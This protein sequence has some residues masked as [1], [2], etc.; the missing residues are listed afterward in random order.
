MN[1][2]FAVVSAALLAWLA[3]IL[4]AAPAAQATGIPQQ[5]VLDT[6]SVRGCPCTFVMTG[7]FEDEGSIVTDS[8]HAHALASPIVGTATTVRTFIGQHGS[9]T[10][11]LQSMIEPTDNPD[12][13][14]ESGSW[15]VL[16]TTGAY[17]GLDG[18]GKEAGVRDFAHQSQDVTYTGLLH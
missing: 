16:E 13:Y 7:A 1:G 5:V 2:R 17:D 18:W 3:P 11:R 14:T 12:L 15:V 10:I 4:L 9:L 6:F 8:V